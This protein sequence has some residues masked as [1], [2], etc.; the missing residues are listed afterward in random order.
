MPADR[1]HAWP[2]ALALCAGGTGADAIAAAAAPA[3]RDAAAVDA[4]LLEFLGE[5]SADDGKFVDPFALDKVGKAL[6]KEIEKLDAESAKAAKAPP[7]A[8]KEDDDGR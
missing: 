2:L 1:R 3:A 7:A 6:E 4:E 8:P 5:F